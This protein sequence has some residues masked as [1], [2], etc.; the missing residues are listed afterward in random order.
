MASCKVGLRRTRENEKFL[1]A[2][3]RKEKALSN[4]YLPQAY[5]VSSNSSSSNC[6]CLVKKS[7]LILL[8]PHGCAL[9][10]PSVHGISQ[11]RILEWVAISFSEDF[12]GLEIKSTSPAWQASSLPVSHRGNPSS[13]ISS[14]Q[15]LSYINLIL[16]KNLC[17]SKWK[18]GRKRSLN[19][20]TLL[21]ETSCYE[22]YSV[23]LDVVLW[24]PFLEKEKEVLPT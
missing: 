17:T 11:A 6:G 18:K 9:P 23:N 1:F 2:V 8:W 24:R 21:D 20:I 15:N 4:S 12:P 7:C 19:L 14:G 5:N 13:S 10:G 22:Q 16:I 3:Q